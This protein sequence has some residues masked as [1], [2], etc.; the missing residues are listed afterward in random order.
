MFSRRFVPHRS[1]GRLSACLPATKERPCS[2]G[3]TA[4]RA[5]WQQSLNTAA[6]SPPAPCPPPP[7][8]RTFQRFAIRSNAMVEEV[9]KKGVQ[10]KQQLGEQGSQFFKVFQEE[11]SAAAAPPPPLLLLLASRLGPRPAALSAC[12][13][14]LRQISCVAARARALTP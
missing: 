13:A 11:V 8:S 12:C 1:L 14:P 6:A 9:A 5:A 3:R 4:G 10:Q 2:R 7:C